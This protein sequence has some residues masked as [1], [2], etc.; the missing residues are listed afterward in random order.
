VVARDGRSNHRPNPGDIFLCAAAIVN[1]GS[2]AFVLHQRSG[3]AA[4]LR[5]EE[6]GESFHLLAARPR[7]RL[8]EAQIAAENLQPVISGV[9]QSFYANAAVEVFHSASADDADGE[10]FLAGDGSQRFGG[11]AIQS[12]FRRFR[13]D[14]HKGAIEIQEQG[15]PRGGGKAAFNVRN[16]LRQQSR[17]AVSRMGGLGKGDVIS[18]R[19][20]SNRLA[21]ERFGTAGERQGL[22]GGLCR[23]PC[24]AIRCL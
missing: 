19:E 21:N 15:N 16:Q 12:R 3:H 22:I 8:H 6:V 7:E 20:C 4:Q 9:N 5:R 11:V 2:Q 14:R 17:H 10:K 23:V 24:R 1:A 13:R 18:S